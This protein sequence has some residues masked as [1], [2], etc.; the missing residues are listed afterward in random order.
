MSV[1]IGLRTSERGTRWQCDCLMH[2]GLTLIDKKVYRREGDGWQS[3]SDAAK[4]AVDHGQNV[5]RGMFEVDFLASLD[6]AA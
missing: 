1:S 4:G 5:H 2:G 6:G 3:R